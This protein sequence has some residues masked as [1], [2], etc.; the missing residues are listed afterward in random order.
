MK[1]PTAIQHFFN[2]DDLEAAVNAFAADAVVKDEGHTYSGR[3]AIREWRVAS[4][5]MYDF[6]S[7]PFDLFI[8]DDV[9]TVRAN[10][11][12]NFPGSPVV[13]DYDFRLMA[14]RIVELEIGY[15]ELPRT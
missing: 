14:E 1:M 3:Q 9:V 13:L 12:G 10:V 6:V 5:K 11:C 2:E 15:A 4:R 8:R 7:E